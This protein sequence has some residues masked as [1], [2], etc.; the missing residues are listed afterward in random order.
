MMLKGFVL[1][2]GVVL[3]AM[4]TDLLAQVGGCSACETAIRDKLT[5]LDDRTSKTNLL[6]K[7]VDRKLDPLA[8]KVD[9]IDTKLTAVQAKLDGIAAAAPP[10]KSAVVIEFSPGNG[11]L[12]ITDANAFCRSINYAAGKAITMSQSFATVVSSLVC[13]M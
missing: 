9:T 4:P 7:T 2:G 12:Q 8:V 6:V 1:V 10:T 3:A 13:Y 11:N 5:E